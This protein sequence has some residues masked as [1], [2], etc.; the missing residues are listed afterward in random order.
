MAEELHW[1]MKRAHKENALAALSVLREFLGGEYGPKDVANELVESGD[2]FDRG[3]SY[4]R[5][6]A[7]FA[8]RIGNG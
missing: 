6:N 7:G 5:G 1:I 8:D 3:P 2:K 4:G